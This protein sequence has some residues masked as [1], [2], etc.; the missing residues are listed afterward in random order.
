MVGRLDAPVE[1]EHNCAGAAPTRAATDGAESWAVSW[2]TR[3]ATN[4]PS[5]CSRPALRRRECWS[6]H[7]AALRSASSSSTVSSLLFPRGAPLCLCCSCFSW[8]SAP[9]R[10]TGERR[11][12]CSQVFVRYSS[13]TSNEHTRCWILHSTTATLSHHASFSPRNDDHE[14]EQKRPWQ[15]YRAI[16]LT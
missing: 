1:R 12:G 15:M 14:S 11:N 3:A 5:V 6:L 13:R 10:A 4:R 16:E 2:R 9:R 8:R 7:S